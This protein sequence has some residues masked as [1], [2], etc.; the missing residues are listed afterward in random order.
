[1]LFCLRHGDVLT[2]DPRGIQEIVEGDIAVFRRHGRLFAHRVIAIGLQ[3]DLPYIVTRPDTA[4]RGDDG[5]LFE[6]DVLGIIASAERNGRPLS[7][8]PRPPS[9]IGRGL[10][11]CLL[12]GSRIG[13]TAWSG[14]LT[15]VQR[16]Q[17]SIGY[18]RLIGQRIAD[19][20]RQLTCTVQI[21]LHANATTLFRRYPLDSV[22]PAVL[23]CAP[24][25]RWTLSMTLD[26]RPVATLTVKRDMV[27]A[28]T[29]WVESLVVRMRYRG[30][31]FDAHALS[32]V[33]ALL[34]RVGAARLQSA[35]PIIGA[36][37]LGFI[38]SKD[39]PTI[40][41]RDLRQGGSHD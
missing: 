37:R 18:R 33:E 26:G 6:D 16:G 30:A 2:I 38:V 23:P 22:D 11:S 19:R 4:L 36:R 25:A 14:M 39:D 12:I 21:P 17:E 41:N 8:S 20:Q 9:A 5:L 40:M 28:T 27:D 15:I 24:G 29:W 35:T 34:S 10:V 7:L 1:M 32:I 13:A 3:N 31:G